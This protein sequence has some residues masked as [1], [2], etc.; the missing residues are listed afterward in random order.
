MILV[1]SKRVSKELIT[2]VA[3]GV[4]VEMCGTLPVEVQTYFLLCLWLIM[5]THDT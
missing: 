1:S 3:A 2:A 4:I 5:E